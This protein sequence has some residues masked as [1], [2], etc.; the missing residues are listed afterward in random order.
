M[1]TYERLLVLNEEIG[2]A[3]GGD[4]GVFNNGLCPNW[5]FAEDSDLDCGRLPWIFNVEVANF[6]E[7]NT[8][9]QM[10]GLRL[11]SVLHFVSDGKPWKVLAADY[12]LVQFDANTKALLFKQALAHLLWRQ[13][14]FRCTR[15]SPP[16][17]SVF[18]ELTRTE[19][20]KYN[21]RKKETIKPEKLIENKKS[22]KKKSTG[23]KI[24]KNKK[25]KIK[26]KK[27]EL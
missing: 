8:L 20:Q 18:D 7:Y 2:S 13:A 17:Q 9:R 25:A 12:S 11:P 16:K 14:F 22:K 27:N 5:F 6:N 10:Q 4:Q 26:S 15:D 1:D 24:K 19:E 21:Q 3:E 23:K